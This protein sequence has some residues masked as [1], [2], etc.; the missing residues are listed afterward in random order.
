MV[1]TR[2]I[3]EAVFSRL[4]KMLFGGEV[5]Q[6]TDE[7]TVDVEAVVESNLTLE[8]VDSAH[9]QAKEQA[10]DLYDD[11]RDA[12]DEYQELLEEI[13]DADEVEAENLK[14]PAKKVKRRANKLKQDY[15]VWVAREDA[16]SEA[17][18]ELESSVRTAVAR[19]E[20][21]EVLTLLEDGALEDVI[22]EQE[23][24]VEQAN[25]VAETVAN[26]AGRETDDT[27]ADFSEVEKDLAEREW[28]QLETE[29][30]ERFGNDLLNKDDD[31]DDEEML[32]GGVV[33]DD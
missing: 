13:E 1:T 8:R 32:S 15:D 16:L 3:T 23:A 14:R 9:E 33:R 19:E 11:W 21:D 30:A 22:S 17:A 28:D 27:G 7:A 2:E 29:G 25:T 5:P 31:E 18:E 24:A 20:H 26:A 4:F 10:D 6:E 12:E